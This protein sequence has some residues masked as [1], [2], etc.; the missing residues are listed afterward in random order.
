MKRMVSVGI[1][2]VLFLMLFVPVSAVQPEVVFTFSLS[3]GPAD[4][5]PIGVTCGG[6]PVM[7]DEVGSGSIIVYVDSEGLP[8]KMVTE[9]SGWDNLYT[10]AEPFV[11]LSGH[12][13]FKYID[14]GFTGEYAELPWDPSVIVPVMQ[15]SHFSGQHWNIHAPGLGNVI[16]DVGSER[17]DFDQE[18]PLLKKVGLEVFDAEKLCKGLGY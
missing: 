9:F 14:T 6:Y 7:D 5:S 16:R 15:Y 2:V 13:A 10:G 18:S 17:W 12:F 4:D 3:A 11:V 8:T 1:A